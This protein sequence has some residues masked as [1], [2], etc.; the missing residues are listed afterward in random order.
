[1]TRKASPRSELTALLDAFERE[2][3][4]ASLDEVGDALDEAGRGNIICREVRALLNEAIAAS[5][6]GSAATL[7]SDTR[8][9]VRFGVSKELRAGALS[10]PHAG[11]ILPRSYRPH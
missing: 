6:D 9:G 10:H 3:L 5:E 7:W 11:A 8:A 1:M 2:I 4:A